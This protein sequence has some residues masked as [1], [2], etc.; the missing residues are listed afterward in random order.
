MVS[1]EFPDRTQALAGAV[2]NTVAQLGSS[3][4]LAT[5]A[6]ISRAVMSHSDRADEMS[7]AA[8]IEGY[9]AAFWTLFACMVTA[10]VVGTVG[11]RKLGRIGEKRD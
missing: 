10:C 2:F 5:T 11:L 9:R 7:A 1:N 3:I 4:G 8:S 6:V